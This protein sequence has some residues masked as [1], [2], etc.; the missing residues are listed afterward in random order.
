M[1]ATTAINI[2]RPD[3][4]VLGPFTHLV[5]AT[6]SDLCRPTRHHEAALEAAGFTPLNVFVKVAN[7]RGRPVT[8]TCHR[9][10]FLVIKNAA[11]HSQR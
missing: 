11:G 3:A 7:E 1:V 10:L 4:C 9:T 6:G 2:F 8:C 5:R